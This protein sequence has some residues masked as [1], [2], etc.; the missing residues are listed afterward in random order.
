MN[1]YDTI[2][3]LCHAV[4]VAMAVIVL[5]DSDGVDCVHCMNH[6]QLHA[7]AYHSQSIIKWRLHNHEL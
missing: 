5:S 4:N 2:I 1:A 6:G 7:D 3:I